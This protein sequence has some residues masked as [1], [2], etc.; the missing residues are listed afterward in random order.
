M[1][2][3]KVVFLITV[4]ILSSAVSIASNRIKRNHISSLR[5]ADGEW[6]KSV[7]LIVTWD[8]IIEDKCCKFEEYWE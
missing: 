3:L 1:K 8:R 2:S 6:Q 4:L 7:G 5:K